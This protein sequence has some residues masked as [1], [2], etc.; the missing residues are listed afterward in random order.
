LIEES[1]VLKKELPEDRKIREYEEGLEK[2]I[3]E[4]AEAE[5]EMESEVA[6][7]ARFHAI[8]LARVGRLF[9][10]DDALSLA[11]AQEKQRQ[12]PGDEGLAAEAAEAEARMN[13]SRDEADRAQIESVAEITPD[14]KA[15]YREAIRM[16]HPDLATDEKDRSYRTEL[17]KALND[18][19]RRG[20]ADAVS[21]IMRDFQL[22]E[23]P[24]N[25]GKRLIILIRQEHDL[26]QRLKDVRE[27]LDEIRNGD[28]AR[29]KKIHAEAGAEGAD[30]FSDLIKAALDEIARKSGELAKMGV[31][32]VKFAKI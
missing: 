15:Q 19:Y 8:Y 9:L 6:E 7:L 3:A 24:D 18:A 25:A 26:G 31:I 21:A 14:L 13:A 10:F 2:L 5:A 22:A 12:S 23:M 29:M 4:V 30:S 32:P 27:K 17:T 1:A 11:L 28:L 16:I 20:D